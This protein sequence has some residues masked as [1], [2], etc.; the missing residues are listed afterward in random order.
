MFD[1]LVGLVADRNPDF[2]Q[3]QDGGIVS[4]F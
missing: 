1:A 3:V 4:A 2:Y